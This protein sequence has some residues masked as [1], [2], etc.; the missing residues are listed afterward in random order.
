MKGA[1]LRLDRVCVAPEARAAQLVFDVSF[2]V[3]R[4]GTLALL[5]PSGAGKTTLLRGIAGLAAVTAGTVWVDATNVAG[6]DTH[7][8]PARRR[9]GM[10]FQHG[11]LWPHLDVG[12]HIRL[13]LR[14]SG[15]RARR[16]EIESW[17]QRV[18]LDPRLRRRKPGRLSGG[19]RQ[20]VALARTLAA[21][22]AIVLYDEPFSHLDPGRRG[23][24]RTLLRQLTREEEH[25]AVLVSHDPEDAF[26]LADEVCVMDGG[27]VVEQGPPRT[28]YD[29]PRTLVGARALGPVAL[30]RGR[31]SPEGL[32]TVCGTLGAAPQP[33]EPASEGVALV[34]ADRVHED[35]ASAVVGTV[36]D[37]ASTA[38]G[39]LVS[40]KID[41]EHIVA[42]TRTRPALGDLLH[43]RVDR[44]VPWVART[45][46]PATSSTLQEVGT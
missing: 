42:S 43:V 28:L 14:A 39:Y 26:A 20:R 32:V 31:V 7:V 8:A 13:A 4:G 3:P 24:L 19:E 23:A 1:T 11:E 2:E 38:S 45:D 34:R 40:I 22:P 17:M 27:R 41:G 21:R 36:H 30:L 25:T 15:Q 6:P 18:G 10:V 37:V 16:A 9:I 35:G 5:G 29:A 12:E 46:A 33:G 44:D